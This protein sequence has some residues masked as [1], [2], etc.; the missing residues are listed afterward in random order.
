LATLTASN[1]RRSRNER[2][3]LTIVKIPPM[4]RFCPSDVCSPKIGK[5]R[6]CVTTATP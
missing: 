2:A 1:T 3:K 4:A 5:I 6:I